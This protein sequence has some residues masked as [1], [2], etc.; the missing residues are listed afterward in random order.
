MQIL[1][2]YIF[3]QLFIGFLLIALGL[4]ALI[5]LSQS[6]RMIDWIVNKGVAIGLF[7]QLTLLALPNFVAII[8]PIAFFVTLMFVYHRLMA[9]KE[10]VVMKAC[11]MNLWQLIRPAFYLATLLVVLG[12]ILTLWLIPSS[13][14]QFKNLQFKIR[15][16]LVHVSIQ[17]G[18]FNVLPN[19]IVVYTRVWD[20]ENNI[21]V[22]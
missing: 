20:A 2:R 3:K 15:N 18:V 22:I 21:S 8:T 14:A 10:L 16:G 1:N 6:L 11:G 17:E 12:Y 5:W 4:T 9:D 7:V 19:N 13:V